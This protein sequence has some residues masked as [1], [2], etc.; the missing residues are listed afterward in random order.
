LIPEPASVRPTD[1]GALLR[2]GMVVAADDPAADVASLLAGELEAATG[3]RVERAPAVA[4]SPG[5][6]VRLVVD[7]RLAA[8]A[9]ASRAHAARSGPSG[10]AGVESYRLLVNAD[11]IEIVAPSAAG[12]FY[13]TRTL[14]QLMPADLLRAAPSR[15]GRDSVEVGGILVEDAPRFAWRGMLLDVSRHFLPKSFILKL[16]DLASFHKLNVLHLHLTDDQ[17]WRVPIDKYPR[18]VEIG[19][20]RRESPAGHWSEGEGRFDGVPHGG[21]YSKSD[22][23]EIV[24]YAAR[25]FV[26]V[27]PEID[28]PGHMLAAIAAYPELGNTGEQF[29]VCTRWGI[30]DHVLNLEEP[31][32]AFCTDVLDEVLEIF[33]SRYIHI[34]GDECPTSEW[35]ASEAAQRLRRQLGLADGRALQGWFTGRIAA[36]LSGRGRV[37]VGWDEVLEPAAPAGM[38]VIAWR[39]Q[40]LG[41]EAAEAGHDVVLQPMQ[42]CYFD[43]SY[44]DDPR[45]PIAI[46]PETSVEKVYGF[47]PVPQE[48]APELHHHV[49]GAQ[50]ALWTEYVPNERHAE[51][52]YF[53]RACAFAEVA[54]SPAAREWSEF[55]PRLRRHLARLDALGVN[56]RPLEGPTPGQARVWTGASK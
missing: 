32:I 40:Q 26:N 41:L 31:T 13:G 3:W 5:G 36:F 2:S 8:T 39:A 19:A 38:T 51:Y 44:A 10:Y 50:C 47:E 21:W 15:P 42:W 24:A 18:L 29:E 37:P 48:L 6:V 46:F 7:P 23:A 52:M 4:T 35:E 17:G 49:L 9:S 43:W 28:M 55:E 22:L 20:W 11:G 45:E 30:S 33:P 25:R 16:I 12:L 56:Y 54:W 27:T 1:A 34:G 14:R 53:P